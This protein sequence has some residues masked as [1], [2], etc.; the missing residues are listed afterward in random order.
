MKFIRSVEPDAYS[1]ALKRLQFL[2]SGLQ[3]LHEQQPDQ[4]PADLDALRVGLQKRGY[5][6]TWITEA[7]EQSIDAKD[8]ALYGYTDRKEKTHTFELVP[9]EEGSGLPPSIAAPQIKPSATLVWERDDE[10]NL[11]SQVDYGRG[12]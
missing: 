5:K 3:F 8:D 12:R 6:M 1:T 2:G 7:G 10:G 11:R 9:A 4:P